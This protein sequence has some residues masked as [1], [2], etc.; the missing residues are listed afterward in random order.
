MQSWQNYV[1]PNNFLA[2]FLSSDLYAFAWFIWFIW[3]Y[4]L[5]EVAQVDGYQYFKSSKL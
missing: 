3:F 5:G 1:C 4:L 2:L